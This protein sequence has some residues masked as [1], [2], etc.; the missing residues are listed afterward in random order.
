MSGK[1]RKRRKKM[2]GDAGKIKRRANRQG[3]KVGGW[4]KIQD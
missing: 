4:R 1:R 3:K 2:K